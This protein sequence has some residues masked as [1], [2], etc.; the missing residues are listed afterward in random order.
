VGGDQKV[1]LADFGIREP[2]EKEAL[3]AVRAVW[4]DTTKVH[5]APE[6]GGKAVY[7]HKFGGPKHKAGGANDWG[8]KGPRLPMLMYDVR[9]K[10]LEFAGG[11]YTLPDVGIDG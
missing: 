3:G 6:D 8:S 11:G 1:N 5:L 7:H 2:H 9:N 10:L 4:Y